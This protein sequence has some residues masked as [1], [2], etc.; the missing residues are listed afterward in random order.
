MG[1]VLLTILLPII[2]AAA[3]IAAVLGI[4]RVIETITTA[5]LSR[6]AKA[7]GQAGTA[8][9]WISILIVILVSTPVWVPPFRTLIGI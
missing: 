7:K 8:L 5:M 2:F 3:S 4:P 6:D 1:A 9:L